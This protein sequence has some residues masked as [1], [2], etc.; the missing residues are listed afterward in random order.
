MASRIEVKHYLAHWFQLGKQV[1]SDDG[2]VSYS[3]QS[4]IQGDHFSP[5]FEQCWTEIMK[6]EGDTYYLKGTD[7]TI[8]QLL[9]P[10]WDIVDCARCE[11]P[12]PAAQKEITPYPCPCSDIPNWP[13]EEIPRPRLPVNSQQRLEALADRLQANSVE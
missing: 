8:A 7:Q 13:N 2:Q 5:E 6:T 11:M 10:V 4:V 12:V 9:S 1:V 3:P